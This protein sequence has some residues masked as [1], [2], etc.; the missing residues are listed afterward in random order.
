M[1]YIL[2]TRVESRFARVNLKHITF[3]VEFIAISR[4]LLM[5]EHARARA[6]THTHT[7][8]HT[9]KC[10][11]SCIYKRFGC[12]YRYDTHANSNTADAYMYV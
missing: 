12:S 9:L 3:G 1:I 10:V 8:K 4:H 11:S 5:W 7:H 2:L 6:Q